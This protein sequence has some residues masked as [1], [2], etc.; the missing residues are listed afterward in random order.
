[1]LFKLL[2]LQVLKMSKTDVEL[3]NDWSKDKTILHFL[4]LFFIIMLKI[5][6]VDEE[7]H[8]S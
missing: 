8:L 5:G 7:L 6:N 4:K 3:R 1:M 2:I